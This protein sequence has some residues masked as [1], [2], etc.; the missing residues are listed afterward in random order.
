MAMKD[1]NPLSSVNLIEEENLLI[2]PSLEVIDA[3]NIAKI[4]T[5]IGLIEKLPIAIQIRFGDWIIFHV[6]LPG[7]SEENLSW[8]NR[9]G[10]VVSLKHHSSLYERV[11]ATERNVNW[12]EEN[13]LPE[14]EYAIHGGGIPLKTQQKGFVGSF[15]IS[16]LPQIED[17]KFGVRVLTKYLDDSGKYS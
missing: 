2:L 15:L 11:S 16:G 6:S 8:L 13:N 9:K 10:K 12:F 4:A 5:S 7:S 1:L 17:H 3:I 14:Q